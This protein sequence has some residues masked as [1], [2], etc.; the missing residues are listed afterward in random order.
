VGRKELKVLKQNCDP[1]DSQD[2]SLPY[3]AYLVEYKQDG[4]SV[5]DLAIANKAVDLFDYYYDLYKKNFVKFT[6]SEG[7]I[8][9][10][11]WNDPNQPKPPKKG[12]KK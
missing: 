12:R 7:R 9:P 5:Y 1:K 6:Q 11:L 8:N 2:P 4:K 3:T 10:K